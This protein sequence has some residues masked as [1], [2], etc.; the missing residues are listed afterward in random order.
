LV[1]LLRHLGLLAIGIGLAAG[2]LRRLLGGM[3]GRLSLLGRG[4]L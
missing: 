1:A 3:L 2:V 4:G